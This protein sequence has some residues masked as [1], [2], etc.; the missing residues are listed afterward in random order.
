MTDLVRRAN[1]L[2]INSAFVRSAE[3]KGG[4]KKGRDGCRWFEKPSKTAAPAGPREILSIVKR[5]NAAPHNKRKQQLTRRRI[6]RCARQKEGGRA[7]RAD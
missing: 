7:R 5:D 3:K 2:R 6:P 1:S 4:G